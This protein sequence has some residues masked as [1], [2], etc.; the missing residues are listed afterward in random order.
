MILKSLSVVGF[1]G[2]VGPR[3]RVEAGQ[4]FG[5]RVVVIRTGVRTTDNNRGV[6]LRCDCEPDRYYVVATRNLLVP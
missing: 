1:V 3:L 2:V 6:I 4:R 5:R